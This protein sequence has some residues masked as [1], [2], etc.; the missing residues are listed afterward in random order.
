MI[1]PQFQVAIVSSD[2][3]IC[4][5]SE[6]ADPCN[7]LNETLNRFFPDLIVSDL[8]AADQWLKFP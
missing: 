6:V 8:K 4:R 3:A 2:L 1:V 5:Q 7:C